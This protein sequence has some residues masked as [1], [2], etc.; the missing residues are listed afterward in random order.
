MLFNLC[1]P[2]FIYVIFSLAHIIID[3]YKGHY[4]TALLKFI[5]SVLF[6]VMLD[7]LCKTGLSVISWIIVFIPFIFMTLIVTIL[8]Y[9]FGLDIAT[10]RQYQNTV[11]NSNTLSSSLSSSLYPSLYPSLSPLFSSDIQYKS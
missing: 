3:T 5:V 1:P 4:N 7:A 6:T 8:L 11:I 2:A 10:G 9:V